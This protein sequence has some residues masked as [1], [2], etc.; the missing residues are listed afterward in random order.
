MSVL[1]ETPSSIFFQ[2]VTI[3]DMSLLQFYVIA[4]VSKHFNI[5]A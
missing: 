4:T 2:R 1:I 5:N 3:F